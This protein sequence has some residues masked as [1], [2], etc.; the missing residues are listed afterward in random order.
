VNRSIEP[1]GVK[2]NHLE[3]YRLWYIKL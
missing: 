2:D 1:T 3:R